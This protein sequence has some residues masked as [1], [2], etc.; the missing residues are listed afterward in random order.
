MTAPIPDAAISVLPPPPAGWERVA[1]APLA[2]G[3]LGILETANKLDDG[4]LEGN[5]PLDGRGAPTNARIW[6]FDGNALFE[7]PTFSIS[8]PC[9]IIDRFSDGRW[10]VV[11]ART[12]DS[13]NGVILTP[14]GREVR[15]VN[16]GDGI[17]WTKIDDA[18]R[19]WVGWF[20]E[21]VFGNASW[22]VPGFERPP[23]SYGLAAFDEF[24]SPVAHAPEREEIA[25]CYALNVFGDAVWASTFPG[26]PIGSLTGSGQWH[27]WTTQITGTRA[28]AVEGAFVLAAGGYGSE[29]NR[30]VLLRLADGGFERLG[31][32][33]LPLMAGFPNRV[34]CIDGRSDRLHIVDDGKWYQWRVRDFVA[35]AHS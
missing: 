8:S 5:A 21:G 25:D 24:G 30:V 2:D 31:E 6:S 23:S 17:F 33:R 27:W 15:R 20:D 14:E 3:K 22:R 29:G 4:V 1:Y 34:D 28:L 7:G 26:F 12:D 32:W 13:A 9:P 10:L 35:A 19:I 16:L 11:S 18:D